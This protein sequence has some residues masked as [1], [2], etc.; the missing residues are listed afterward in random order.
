MQKNLRIFLGCSVLAMS[1]NA[2]AQQGRQMSLPGQ[3]PSPVAPPLMIEAGDWD[4]PPPNTTNSR[5]LFAEPAAAPAPPPATRP[6]PEK[7]RGPVAAES[8]PRLPLA[9][10]AAKTAPDAPAPKAP[11]TDDAKPV[12]PLPPVTFTPIDT[13]K[14]TWGSLKAGA[15]SNF[16]PMAPAPKPEV[17][18]VPPKTIAAPGPSDIGPKVAPVKKAAS[19]D[20]AVDDSKKVAAP[21]LAP[22]KPRFTGNQ[23]K[24]KAPDLSVL[25]KGSADNGDVLRMSRKFAD[26]TLS[27]DMQLELN[28]RVCRIEQSLPHSDGDKLVW[29]IATKSN[30]R[31]AIVFEFS[32]KVDPDQGFEVSFSGFEKS[33]PATDW[34]CAAGKCQAAMDIVGPVAGWFSDAPQIAFAFTRSGQKVKLAASMNGFQQAMSASQNPLGGGKAEAAAPPTQPKADKTAQL[35]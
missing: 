6:A 15:E 9:K 28:E 19:I 30:G 3:A 33:L 22:E 25:A 12:P 18:E 16:E 4:A 5:S 13:T 21:I 10:T 17:V 23:G 8:G 20:K 14:A 34:S 7:V 2:Y 32:E 35:K 24:A 26:W 31:P 1:V 27:C 11:G 29:K